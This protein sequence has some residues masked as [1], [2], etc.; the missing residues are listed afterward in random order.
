MST[1]TAPA[2]APAG[3]AVYRSVGPFDENTLPKGL[4]STHRL[5]R[6][7]WGRIIVHGGSVRMVWESGPKKSELLIAGSATLIPPDRPHHLDLMGP[8][9]LAIDFLR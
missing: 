9:S 1:L 6:D 2:E 4:L 8:V 3:L 5:K 7:S